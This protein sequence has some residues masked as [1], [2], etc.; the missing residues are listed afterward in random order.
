MPFNPW[1]PQQMGSRPKPNGKYR[2]IVN[3][4]FPHG[5]L[6]DDYGVRTH[7]LNSLSKRS[8]DAVRGSD[9]KRMC[10]M[11]AMVRVTARSPPPHAESLGAVA[12]L[13]G[14]AFAP[15]LGKIRVE[16]AEAT[17]PWSVSG[18]AGSRAKAAH[19]EADLIRLRRLPEV[20][21]SL[22]GP[23]GRS[24]ASSRCALEDVGRTTAARRDDYRDSAPRDF[25]SNSPVVV[26]ERN[27][28]ARGGHH[29]HRVH[30]RVGLCHYALVRRVVPQLVASTHTR[31]GAA[32]A[33][34]PAFIR[35][36]TRGCEEMQH[37]PCSRAS[38]RERSALRTVEQAR[39]RLDSARHRVQVTS[40]RRTARGELQAAPARNAS[41][42][43]RLEGGTSTRR[44]LCLRRIALD[45]KL[46]RDGERRAIWVSLE[47]VVGITGR[48]LLNWARGVERGA[49]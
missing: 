4:S 22:H 3:A 27:S 46:G 32:D 23:A 21:H 35:K 33:E 9:G 30:P 13:P 44:D 24:V 12:P 47:H 31:V 28:R 45:P 1:R 2:V 37:L 17:H 11:L 10:R 34:A 16:R 14:A 19:I 18:G 29:D 26:G 42:Q 40:A 8:Y 39:L 36:I 48:A 6:A 7:S 38:R 25:D 43:H 15:R 41:G 49:E 20:D 5:E